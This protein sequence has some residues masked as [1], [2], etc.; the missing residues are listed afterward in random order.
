M[1]MCIVPVSKMC[2]LQPEEGCWACRRDHE[3]QLQPV[4][5]RD[6]FDR[7]RSLSGQ[8]DV[9]DTGMNLLAIYNHWACALRS[10]C[11]LQ[12]NCHNI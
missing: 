8:M 1:A 10:G 9:N 5:G 2:H 7:I 12:T 6:L 3:S 11:L 4:P